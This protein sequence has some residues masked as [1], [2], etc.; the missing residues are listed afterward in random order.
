MQNQIIGSAPDAP[1]P[2]PQVGPAR[3]PGGPMPFDTL[4]QGLAL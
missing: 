3:P 4:R 2:S 1:L